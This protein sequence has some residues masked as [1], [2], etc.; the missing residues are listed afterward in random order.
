MVFFHGENDKTTDMKIET[1]HII[2][3]WRL[4]YMKLYDKSGQVIL[5]EEESYCDKK[6]VYDSKKIFWRFYWIYSM[7]RY[8]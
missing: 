5:N 1:E 2:S 7:K 8:E 6:G 4:V 3:V